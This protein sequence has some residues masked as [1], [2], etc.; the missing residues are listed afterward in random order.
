MS[1]NLYDT[2]ALNALVST[3]KRVP[4]RFVTRYFGDVLN[5]TTEEIYIDRMTDKPRLTPFVHPMEQGKIVEGRGFTTDVVKPAYLK[6]KRIHYPHKALKRRAG[7]QIGGS[8]TPNQRLQLVLVDDLSEQLRMF[9]RRMEW[10]AAEALLDGKATIVG[11]GFNSLVDFNRDLSLT[12]ALAG[13]TAGNITC[14]WDQ[15]DANGKGTAPIVEQFEL[16]MQTL[17]DLD[18]QVEEIY[19]DPK[20]YK[21]LKKNTQFKELL[22]NNFRG[23]DNVDLNRTPVAFEDGIERQVGTIDGIIP[24]YVYQATAR[25]PETDA[26]KKIMPDNT[27]LLVGKKVQGVRHFGAIQD[28]KAGLQAMETFTKSWENE[29]PS[30][31]LLLMQSAPL[32][33][34]YFPNSSMKITVA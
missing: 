17:M 5:H 10:M 11:K 1:V 4:T 29:D 31:R 8:L 6:D 21:L 24:V 26:V 7:E 25:D 32:L 20:A 33:V 28:L 19:M 14:K 13:T 30:V 23:S 34:P 15:V 22:D 18:G 2:Y 12:A 27:V 9:A 3:M 16:W